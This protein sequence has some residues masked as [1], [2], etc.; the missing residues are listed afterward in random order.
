MPDAKLASIPTFVLPDRYKDRV[1]HPLPA[2]V[3]NSKHKF[4]VPIGGW[5]QQGNSC[6]N[7][8]AVSLVY[9]F[10]AQSATNVALERNVPDLHL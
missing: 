4:F 9:G 3:D 10:E 6:A 5:S 8:Q 2:S 7:A 1:A